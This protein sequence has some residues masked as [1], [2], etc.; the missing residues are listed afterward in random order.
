[1]KSIKKDK[2]GVLLIGPVA[3]PVG[4]MSVSLNNLMTSDL[5]DKYDLCLLDVTGYRARNKKATL[6]MGACYQI[7]LMVKLAYILVMKNPRIVHVQMANFFYFYSRSIDIIVC[8]LFGRKVIFHLRG[9]KFREFYGKSSLLGKKYIKFMLKI[10]D[11]IIALSDSWR[12]FL[13]TIAKKEKIIVVPNGVRCEEFGL[14]NNKK[15]ELGFHED[16][17]F[18]VYISPIAQSKGAFDIIEAIPK[19]TEKIKNITFIFCGP[20]EF[21]GELEK[22]KRKVSERALDKFVIYAGM[23]YGQ[24]KVDYYMSSD[25]F[26]LPSYAENLPNALLEAMAAGLAVV[27][28]D[29]GAIPEIVKDGVNGFLIK[30][31]DVDAIAQNIIKLAGDAESRKY[32]GKKNRE[33]ALEKY[34]MRIIAERIDEV[35][36]C[37]LGH[38]TN[39]N[40]PVSIIASS[41][42][43]IERGPRDRNIKAAVNWLCHA[44][45]VCKD[46]CKGGGIPGWYSFLKGWSPC[47][48]ETTGYTIPTLLKYFKK[49]KDEEYRMR[50]I[51]IADWLLSVQLENGAFPGHHMGVKPVVPR[52][53][54]SGQI[55]SGLLDIFKETNEEKYIAAAKRAAEFII[56]TQDKDGAWRKYAFNNIAHTYYS[57]VSWIML[58]LHG[59]APDIR[60]VESAKKNLDWV[61]SQKREDGW[62]DH[63]AF[64]NNHNVFT[65]TLAYMV[66]GLL[67][68]GIILDDNRYIKHA[69]DIAYRLMRIFEMK[70]TMPGDFDSDWRGNFK[71]TCITGDAQISIIWQRAYQLNNDIRL[72][73]TAI[74]MNDYL[75][76][77]QVVSSPFKALRGGLPGSSP[78]WGAYLPCWIPEWGAKFFIDSLLLEDEIMAG[79][80]KNIG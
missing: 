51:R 78:F 64:E 20:E 69:V 30:A 68:S 34:D 3:P 48:P 41:P 80:R 36:Q 2:I 44:Q 9:G 12:G 77:K 22:F 25:I 33:L 24:E 65:H 11:R 28:S 14:A 57:R 66:E 32:M 50:A 23:V 76:A 17:I 52:V 63:C 53:F 27:V 38:R 13:A 4:G 61:L 49:T 56:E 26:L 5:K 46:R 55:L 70:K 37:L 18:A 40:R 29:A 16:H 59:V 54:N 7:Y 67:E 43:A 1:M 47:Y 35:Y 8:K 58:I 79:L 75:A 62:F 31:G 73:N 45:D 6:L 71:Y 21:T 19:V 42:N 10:S 60:Y 39:E 15:K 74:K 72:L